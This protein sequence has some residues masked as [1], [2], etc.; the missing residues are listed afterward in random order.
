MSARKSRRARA[1]PAPQDGF[2]ATTNATPERFVTSG[3][4]QEDTLVR[5]HID[6]DLAAWEQAIAHAK[7]GGRWSEAWI[8]AESGESSDP[9]AESGDDEISRSVLA[10]TMLEAFDDDERWRELARTGRAL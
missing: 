5:A 1:T 7:Q 10:G 2:E 4:P 3:L 9:E 6:P 8:A